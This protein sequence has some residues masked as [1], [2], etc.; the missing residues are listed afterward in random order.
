MSDNFD[1]LVLRSLIL[2]NVSGQDSVLGF[3]GLGNAPS[4]S[5]SMV[6]RDHPINCK[7]FRKR[8]CSMDL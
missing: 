4:V 2:L 3:C 6:L 1:K 5:E 7:N 8:H